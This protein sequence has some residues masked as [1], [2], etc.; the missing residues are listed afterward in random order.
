MA[1]GSHQATARTLARYP[2]G[3]AHR[4]LFDDVLRE[5]IGNFHEV[6]GAAGDVILAHPFLFHTRG[7]KRGGPPRIISNTEAGLL[8]PMNFDRADGDY[9][10]LEESIRHALRTAPTVPRYAKLCRF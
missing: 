8:A 2:Q 10:I 9:S 3:V 7:Y 4:T 5:P 1:L 6:T